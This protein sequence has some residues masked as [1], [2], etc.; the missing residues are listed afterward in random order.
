VTTAISIHDADLY[1]LN[2]LRGREKRGF[3][4]ASIPAQEILCG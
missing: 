4:S 2:E 1:F 3:H